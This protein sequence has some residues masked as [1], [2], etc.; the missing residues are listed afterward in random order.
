LV[1]STQLIALTSTS[2]NRHGFIFHRSRA[3]AQKIQHIPL[4]LR[5]RDSEIVHFIND[6][7]LRSHQKNGVWLKKAA[8]FE[9]EYEA[10]K[11]TYTEVS[12]M[13]SPPLEKLDEVLK[14]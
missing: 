2:T 5:E 14:I 12:Q 13:E 4:I 8:S 6:Y 1:V 3:A 9:K 11:K 10:Y 7:I